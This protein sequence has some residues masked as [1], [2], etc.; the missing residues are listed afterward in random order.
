MRDSLRK[1]ASFDVSLTVCRILIESSAFVDRLRATS[2]DAEPRTASNGTPM[3]PDGH[4]NAV[5]GSIASCLVGLGRASVG[6][7]E[8][9]RE[10]SMS[11]QFLL[12]HKIARSFF[13]AIS[14]LKRDVRTVLAQGAGATF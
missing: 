1:S 6:R 2:S 3:Q 12:A 7:V 8:L 5:D 13:M 14:A 9:A 4:P 10:R 11:G